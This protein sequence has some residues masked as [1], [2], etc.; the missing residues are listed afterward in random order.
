LGMPTCGRHGARRAK[1]PDLV[2]SCAVAAVVHRCGIGSDGGR[3]SRLA[4]LA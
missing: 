3:F 4:W 1:G 2:H